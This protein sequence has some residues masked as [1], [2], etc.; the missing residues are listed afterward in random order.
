MRPTT[1]IY[2]D[3]SRSLLHLANKVLQG[4]AQ[5]IIAPNRLFLSFTW[6]RFLYT[7]WK[8]ASVQGDWVCFTFQMDRFYISSKNS[9]KW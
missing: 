1:N 2:Y 8:D 4:T 3:V 9:K 5:V 7:R 6:P